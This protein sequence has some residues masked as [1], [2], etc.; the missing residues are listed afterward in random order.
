MNYLIWHSAHIGTY[1]YGTHADLA[2]EQSLSGETLTI[3]YEMDPSELFLIKKIVRQLN[4]A[5]VEQD[6]RHLVLK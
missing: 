6:N 3:L 2:V 1:N 4:A 5:R